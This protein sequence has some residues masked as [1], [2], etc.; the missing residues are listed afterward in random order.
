[1]NRL[2][3]IGNG[4]DLAHGLK[5]RYSDFMLDYLKGI[6]KS[7]KLTSP[8][9]RDVY[10]DEI[11]RIDTKFFLLNIIV[12]SSDINGC[13]N[14]DDL[15]TL[16]EKYNLQITAQTP[17][18]DQ[19]IVGF[20]QNNWV[21]IENLYY[22]HLLKLVK[23]YS[24]NET[25]QE[26]ALIELKALNNQ[27]SFLKEK[28]VEYLKKVDAEFNIDSILNSNFHNELE[29]VFTEN[30]MTHKQQGRGPGVGSITILNF[31][32]T[33]LVNQYCEKLKDVIFLDQIQLH[34]KLTDPNSIVFGY[35]DEIHASYKEI[36]HLNENEFFEH[37]KS[38]K[39][40]Q[41][42]DYQKLMS[43]IEAD[44]FEV[45]VLGHSLGLSDRTMFNNIFESKNL[46]K[47]HLYYYKN[48]FGY[49]DFTSKTHEISRHFNDKGR[50]RTK[51]VPFEHSKPMPQN[52]LPKS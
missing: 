16:F 31:N 11:I 47:I 45:Y 25:S 21:D 19:I 17:F 23:D 22:Q 48:E 26:E 39:Y 1:M 2:I 38:F 52:T 24:K 20:L 4:F 35:G 15:L 8:V 37:I 6:L 29:L 7:I 36:E 30:V 9:N 51:I 27:M 12:D 33:N 10:K 46:A 28:L 40:F 34:G 50:M 42:S 3:I 41:N 13:N 32:Y 18:I 43:F 14:L 5:T 44:M 49:N